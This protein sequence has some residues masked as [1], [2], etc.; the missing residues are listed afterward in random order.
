M[1]IHYICTNLVDLAPLNL[2]LPM[3]FFCN[4]CATRMSTRD[5]AMCELAQVMFDLLGRAGASP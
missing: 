5:V 3:L 2:V 4:P 1:I